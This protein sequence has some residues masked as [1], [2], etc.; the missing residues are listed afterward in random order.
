MTEEKIGKE[1]LDLKYT[2]ENLALYRAFSIF[3]RGFDVSYLAMIRDWDELKKNIPEEDRPRY[4]EILEDIGY[5]L[6]DM[7]KIPGNLS[8]YYYAT[9]YSIEG[10]I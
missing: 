8:S 4:E 3:M 1:N 6:L 5:L 7:G 2:G 10:G 9:E